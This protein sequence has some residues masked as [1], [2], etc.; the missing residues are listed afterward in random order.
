MQVHACMYAHTL[1]IPTIQL[2]AVSMFILCFFWIN[3]QVSECKIL[4]NAQIFPNIQITLGQISVFKT[5]VTG[6]LT[7]N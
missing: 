3:L 1:C 5:T 4:V 2:S 6:K 7:V